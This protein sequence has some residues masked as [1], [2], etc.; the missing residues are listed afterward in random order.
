MRIENK[1]KNQNNV[2]IS[3]SEK[4]KNLTRNSFD[5]GLIIVT[6]QDSIPWLWITA[7]ALRISYAWIIRGISTNVT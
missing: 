7:P 5:I 2:L 4:N 1:D 3:G 6:R